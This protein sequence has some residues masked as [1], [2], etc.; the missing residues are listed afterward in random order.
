[1]STAPTLLRLGDRGD[2]VRDLQA[3]LTQCG[4]SVTLDGVFGE[5]TLAGVRAFQAPRVES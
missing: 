1:L 3:R 5:E 4:C 2:P